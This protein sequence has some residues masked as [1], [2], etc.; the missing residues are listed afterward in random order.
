MS[1][2]VNTFW[3]RKGYK[4]FM[5]IWDNDTKKLTTGLG[6][7]T[8]L[9]DISEISKSIKEIDTNYEGNFLERDWADKKDLHKTIGSGKR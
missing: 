3:L 5:F 8:K 4:A 6:R 7:E 1:M 9:G 2:F